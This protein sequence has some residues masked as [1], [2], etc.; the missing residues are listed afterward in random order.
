MESAAPD[1]ET[2]EYAFLIQGEVTRNE[3]IT[4]EKK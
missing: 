2:E 4:V 3:N 1:E